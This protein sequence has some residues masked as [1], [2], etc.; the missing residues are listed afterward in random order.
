MWLIGVSTR[1]TP[2]RRMIVMLSDGALSEPI[3]TLASGVTIMAYVLM[4]P[5]EVLYMSTRSFVAFTWT[6]GLRCL[7]TYIREIKS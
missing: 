4:R 6:T 1:G 3:D 7:L 5:S 2:T